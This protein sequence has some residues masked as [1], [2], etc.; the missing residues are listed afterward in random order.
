LQADLEAG[1]HFGPRLEATVLYFQHQ[2][3]LSYERGQAAWADLPALVPSE[4][5]VFGV[6][7]SESGLACI[8]EH[9]GA[10]AAPLAEAP[11]DENRRGAVVHSDK[12]SAQ[13]DGHN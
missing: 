1:R 6:A 11:R 9:A 13:V 2:Q 10:A 4:A 5:R 3:H 8:L 12:T 7:L